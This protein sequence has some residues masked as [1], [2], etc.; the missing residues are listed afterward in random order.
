[1][2]VILGIM[3]TNK[4]AKNATSVVVHVMVI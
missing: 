2:I 3:N 4:I 1:V